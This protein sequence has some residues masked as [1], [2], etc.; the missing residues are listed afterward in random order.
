MEDEKKILSEKEKAFSFVETNA[1]KHF[2]SFNVSDIEEFRSLLKNKSNE[3]IFVWKLFIQNVANERLLAIALD[4]LDSSCM[5]YQ[6]LE[7]SAQ[8]MSWLESIYPKIL[9]LYTMRENI[10][11]ETIWKTIITFICEVITEISQLQLR[12][13]FDIVLTSHPCI[14]SFLKEAQFSLAERN[15]LCEIYL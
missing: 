2:Y 5:S 7:K 10:T 11:E 15:Q 4:A 13:D 9:K 1:N 3:F 14:A 8:L 6:I 12:T